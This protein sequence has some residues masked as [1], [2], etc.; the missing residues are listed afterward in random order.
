MTHFKLCGGLRQLEPGA[1]VLGFKLMTELS[2]L[3]TMS[4]ASI[5]LI[6]S[7]Y[8]AKK[9][10]ERL[11]RHFI[12][13]TDGNLNMYITWPVVIFLARVGP[14]NKGRRGN[15]SNRGEKSKKSTLKGRVGNFNPPFLIMDLITTDSITILV[16]YLLQRLVIII[17]VFVKYVCCHG[18]NVHYLCMYEYKLCTK[19]ISI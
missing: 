8:F 9:F 7:I 3:L 1:C 19:V 12:N 2:F 16:A 4:M 18:D 13:E 17:Y 5:S 15:Y 14:K 10:K 11:G 6:L